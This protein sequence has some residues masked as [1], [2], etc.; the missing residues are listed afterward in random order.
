MSK[1]G[2]LFHLLGEFYGT[3]AYAVWVMQDPIHVKLPEDTACVINTPLPQTTLRWCWRESQ[4]LKHF[5][6]YTTTETESPWQYPF[7]IHRIHHSIMLTSGMYMCGNWDTLPSDFSHRDWPDY[8]TASPTSTLDTSHLINTSPSPKMTL[9]TVSVKWLWF[10]TCS[11]VGSW[12]VERVH[13]YRGSIQC[14]ESN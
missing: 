4:L 11:G 9:L 14:P 13:H 12:I 8:L 10:K 5:C 3:G 7:A 1:K 6:V 2:V